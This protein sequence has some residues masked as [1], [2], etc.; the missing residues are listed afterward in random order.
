M[1]FIESL[2]V[3]CFDYDAI[4]VYTVFCFHRISDMDIIRDFPFSISRPPYEI[5]VHCTLD[6]LVFIKVTRFQL[7]S[8]IN[9]NARRRLASQSVTKN[10]L[11]SDNLIRFNQG[12]KSLRY[13]CF[14][15]KRMCVRNKYR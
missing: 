2:K 11:S 5:T 10:Q 8:L 14:Y 3:G 9:D 12:I 13:F 6:T 15:L 4:L 1:I 7:I